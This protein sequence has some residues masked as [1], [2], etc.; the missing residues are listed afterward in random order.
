[1]A[2]R[3]RETDPRASSTTTS[4]RR[5]AFLGR[6]AGAE[7]E[8]FK[9]SGCCS[10]GSVF[11]IYNLILFTFLIRP[12]QL[13]FHLT[14]LELHL[15]SAHRWR[16]ARIAAAWCS[17]RWPIST[18]TTSCAR[19]DDRDL[20][21]R[22]A[23]IGTAGGIVTLLVYRIVTDSALAANGPPAI[24]IS[25]ETFPP[26]YRGAVR[27]VDAD[28]GAFGALMAAEWAGF[29]LRDFVGAPASLF[30]LPPAVLSASFAAPFPSPT[31]RSSGTPKLVRPGLHPAH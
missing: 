23:A 6:G 26:R 8:H 21:P 3:S 24:L 10:A 4:G 2:G 13:E 15:Y 16:R 29:L 17:E 25:A 5:H 14:K 22:H 11:D 19:V 7:Y 1:M 20:Q 18:G 27:V 12:I 31:S 28:G 30:R 9:M